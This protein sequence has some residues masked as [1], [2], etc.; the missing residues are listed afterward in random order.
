M[1]NILACFRLRKNSSKSLDAKTKDS[2]QSIIN[3][4]LFDLVLFFFSNLSE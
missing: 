1:L 2:L 3:Y 4:R